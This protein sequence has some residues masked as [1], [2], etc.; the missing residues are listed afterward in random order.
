[1]QIT[2][3]TLQALQTS[4]S[5]IFGT[6]FKSKPTPLLSYL[7]MTV[8]S[9]TKTSTYGWMSPLF[10]MRKW[11]G[12][13]VVQNLKANTYLIENDPYEATMAVDRD[14]IEDDQLGLFD[15]RVQELA[16]VGARLPDQL[17][18]A[19]LLAGTTGLGFDGLAMFSASH[20]LDP[21][22]VQS[23][24]G[25]IPFNP[26]GWAFVRATM[27]A[28]TGE[29]G[30]PLGVNPNLVVIPPE[31]EHM[32]KHIFN[33]ETAHGGGTNVQRG[34]AKYLVV[35]ELSGMTDW[36]AFDTTQPI[37]PFIFQLRKP[38]QLVSKTAVTDDNVFWQ[39]EFVWGIDGRAGVGYGPWFLGFYSTGD[40]GDITQPP[41]GATD[42]GF[43]GTTP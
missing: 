35:P 29:N 21:S 31:Y 28:Y 6:A 19:A 42:W 9:T 15:T 1:M 37:K 18:L 14:N 17:I 38:V 40:V 24:T 34:E 8:R 16:Y 43:G 30:E 12:P 11:L 13:R 26:G 32:A 3:A 2:P 33:A 25:A 36:W 7:G 41:T 5:T 10:A 39:K 22:G 4:F 27:Q 23:N 20:T